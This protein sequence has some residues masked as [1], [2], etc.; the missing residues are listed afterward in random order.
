M[1]GPAEHGSKPKAWF[2]RFF[3]PRI[4]DSVRLRVL[5]LVSLWLG[6]LGL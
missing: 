4:E 5:V 6:G 1:T 2:S 3:S